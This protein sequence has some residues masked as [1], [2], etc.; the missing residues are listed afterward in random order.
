ML[1]RRVA[2]PD[3]CEPCLPSP[4]DKPPAGAGWLHEIKH[5]GFRML[6]R[7]NAGGVR[8]FT[9][10][11]H[12]WTGRFPLIVR[13]A[14]SLKAASCLIDGEA[15]ACD[16][17]GLPVFDRL[18]YRRQDGHVFLYAFDLLE[19]DGNDLRHE[20]IE[21]R[22]AALARLI[23]RAKT[24]LVLNEHVDEPGAPRLQARARRHRIEAPRLALSL[25]PVTALGQ[26]Q[27]PKAPSGKA[28]RRRGL[29]SVTCRCLSV[30]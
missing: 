24:G 28:G 9:R 17:D 12:D 10:N 8:L 3:F 7:R 15:V 1:L 14:L 27:E 21:R 30:H 18:R 5:D 2:F 25:R 19:L 4:A 20:P 23:R 29:A 22:K 11:G 13:A 6:V 26:K 16:G